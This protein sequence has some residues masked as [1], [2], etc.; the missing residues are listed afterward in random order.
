MPS[1]NP[2]QNCHTD[3]RPPRNWLTFDIIGDLAFG[4]P[5]GA[6]R[7]AKT[8]FWISVVVDGIFAN[9]IRELMGRVPIAKLLAP[10]VAYKYAHLIRS[11]KAFFALSREK[12]KTRLAQD[13]DR[14]DFFGH[15][16]SEKG[17]HITDDYLLTQAQT[18]IV[19]GSETT[20]TL[21]S[22]C[23]YWLLTNPRALSRLIDEVRSTFTQTADITAESTAPAQMPYLFAVLEES[24][25]IHSSAPFGLP[26]ICPGAEID[27]NYIPAGTIVHTSSWNT[28]HDPKYWHDPWGF[29]PE[30][31]LPAGHQWAEE[32]KFK[33]DLKEANKPFSVGPRACL[34]VNLAYMEM[35]MILTKC[36]FGFLLFCYRGCCGRER[37]DEFD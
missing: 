4:E 28:H 21:L 15:I 9:S 19:A 14:D 22:S 35:R 8:S 6:V 20:A 33:G 1:G 18:L 11:S 13:N 24:L 23:N 36:E 2:F 17:S 31:W 27:G 32:E 3:L 29:H 26:R 37:W 25:R 12:L 34:G 10:L 5:F 7:G 30:R 16:L